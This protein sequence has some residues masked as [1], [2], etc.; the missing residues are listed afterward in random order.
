MHLRPGRSFSGPF[1]VLVP[2][3]IGLAL[4]EVKLGVKAR[5]VIAAT[6]QNNGN[7]KEWLV[8]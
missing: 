1:P 8:F 3:S 4:N 6:E 7:A 2:T 5:S